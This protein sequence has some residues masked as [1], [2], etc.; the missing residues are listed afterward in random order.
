MPACA[1][2]LSCQV[3]DLFSCPAAGSCFGMW[4]SEL[5]WS[6]ACQAT[7]SNCLH[8]CVMHSSLDESQQTLSRAMWHKPA[9][10]GGALLVQDSPLRLHADLQGCRKG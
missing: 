4:S 7:T 10:Q 3:A 1:Y 5:R 8:S 9:L 2:L 6:A